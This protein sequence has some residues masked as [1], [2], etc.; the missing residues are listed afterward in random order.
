MRIKG[1]SFF[2]FLYLA[3]SLLFSKL[4][5]P[6]ARLIRLPY[7]F[8]KK[9]NLSGLKNFTSG[10]SLRIDLHEGSKL[11]IGPDV[12][13]ND[14][15][16]IAVAENVTIGEGCLFA[17][18]VFITDHDHYKNATLPPKKWELKSIPTSIGKNCWVGNNVSILKGVKIGNNCVVG[19]GTIVT[20]SFP[21]NSIIVGNPG[22]KI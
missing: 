6:Q 5:Y 21:D 20:K 13:F 4:F 18:K 16:Q 22:R 12:E 11:F 1:Y 14:H 8:M 17:S 19:A 10:R 9:G 2:T 7:F 3:I 15:C